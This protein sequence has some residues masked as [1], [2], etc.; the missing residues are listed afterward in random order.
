MEVIVIESEAFK[1]LEYLIERAAQLGKE[2]DQIFTLEEAAEYVGVEKQWIYSRRR[3]I[4]FI[5]EA[6]IIRIRKS[7][8]DAF[9][10]TLT[11]KPRIKKP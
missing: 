8:L 11:I 4:G 6:K 9:L 7:A 5:Q 1:R 2:K 3:K 10:E